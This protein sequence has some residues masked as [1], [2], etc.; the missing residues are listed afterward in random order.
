MRTDIDAFSTRVHESVPSPTRATP[1]VV[2]RD[3][4][5]EV[6]QTGPD[7]LRRRLALFADVA[8]VELDWAL[9]LCRARSVL[10]ALYEH[11]RGNVGLADQLR[12]M[13]EVLTSEQP[14]TA[15]DQ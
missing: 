1:V 9:R 12:W 4:L 2:E 6:I 3:R 7:E 11:I 5:N 14:N 10:S 8:M 13:S 15:P